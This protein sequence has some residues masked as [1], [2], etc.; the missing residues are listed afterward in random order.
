MLVVTLYFMGQI[1]KNRLWFY[2]LIIA[3]TLFKYLYIK[4]CTNC[5][6]YCTKIY[7]NSFF[8][9]DTEKCLNCGNEREIEYRGENNM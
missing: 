3:I 7:N 1:D 4:K 6:S 2:I 5:N 9:P 8:L